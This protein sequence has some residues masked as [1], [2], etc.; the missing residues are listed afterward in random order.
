[1]V[2]VVQFTLSLS[3]LVLIHVLFLTYIPVTFQN[4]P[5]NI[6]FHQYSSLEKKKIKMFIQKLTV[7]ILKCH[8]TSWACSS[9]VSQSD[10]PLAVWFH[11]SLVS[12]GTC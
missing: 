1:M 2:V 3:F 6:P 9:C 5:L 7:L 10:V 8:G 12:P 4:I 11:D